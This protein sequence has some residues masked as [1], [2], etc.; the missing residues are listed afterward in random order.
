[1]YL[2]QIVIWYK[3]YK[4]HTRFQNIMSD[5]VNNLYIDY[6]LIL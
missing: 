3:Y 4:I 1:M 2:V 6:M 5:I